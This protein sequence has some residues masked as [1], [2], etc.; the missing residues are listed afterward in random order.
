MAFAETFSGYFA[1]FG[2]AVTFG[3][4]TVTALVDMPALEMIDVLARDILITVPEADVTGVAAG[5]AA[6]V[7]GVS[8]TVRAVVPEGSGLAS[9]FVSKP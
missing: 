5:S 9:I 4:S 1:D 7:R 6:T 8:Y 3:T 2:E